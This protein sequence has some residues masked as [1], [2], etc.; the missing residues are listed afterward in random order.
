MG[1]LCRPGLKGARVQI[2]EESPLRQRGKG[3][4]V[5]GVGIEV[6]DFGIGIRLA[7]PHDLLGVRAVRPQDATGMRIDLRCDERKPALFAHAA[8]QEFHHVR[9]VRA[10]VGTL[11]F[12]HGGC[13]RLAPRLGIGEASREIIGAETVRG[14]G[15]VG[16]DIRAVE[17]QCAIEE[18]GFS[19]AD[20]D[21]IISIYK[22][23]LG[24]DTKPVYLYTTFL[25]DRNHT[26]SSYLRAHSRE[27]VGGGAPVYAYCFMR[28][29]N[30][31][32]FRAVHGVEIPFFLGNVDYAPALWNCDTH[33]DAV[34]LGKA[35]RSAWAAFARTGNPSNPGMP[36][37]KPY[38]SE[39]R[40]TMLV[41]IESRL[42]SRFH[43]EI[44]DYIF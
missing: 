13:E 26:K 22:D 16:R 17:R 25:N 23:L 12:L 4:V 42:E 10:V 40:Y 31:P 38:D 32:E 35:A 3:V 6:V 14:A 44:Y 39:T 20:A 19:S 36:A 11:A 15:G 8:H 21:K 7:E 28:E 29:G 41:D 18:L 30:D 27:L 43:K 2:D 1:C 9:V 24:A 37:W 5:A 34:K 33:T